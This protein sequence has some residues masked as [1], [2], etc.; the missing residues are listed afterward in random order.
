MTRSRARPP[1]TVIRLACP[2]AHNFERALR[3]GARRAAEME[4]VA[5]TLTDLGLSSETGGD[6][7]DQPETGDAKAFADAILP[8]LRS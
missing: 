1:E 3:H 5:K 6:P 4:E 8:A 2:A 7:A